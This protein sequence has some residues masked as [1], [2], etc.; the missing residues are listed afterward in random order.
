[1]S[2]P[3]F[4]MYAEAVDDEKLRLL[5]FEDRWHF[6]AVLCLKAMGTLDNGAPHLERRI[7]LKLGLQ[8]PQLDEVKRRLVDV[9][10]ITNDWQPVKWDSRQYDSDISTQRVRRFREKRKGNVSETDQIRTDTEQIQNRSEETPAVAGLDVD[11]WTAWTV[12]RK[13]IGKPVKQASIP[14]AQRKLA[15][16]G[17]SQAAVVEQSIAHGW[18]GF[19][20]LKE[21]SGGGLAAAKPMSK[22]ERAKAALGETRDEGFG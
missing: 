13:Q 14:A 5:A 2:L 12:Y 15:A 7:A 10:L 8:L 3:W 18:Q 17:T 16:H 11:A 22:F 6:V 20:P 1:M 21:G 19:F 4:R 9:C